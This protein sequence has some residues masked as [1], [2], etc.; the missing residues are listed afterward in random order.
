MSGR[1]R[2]RLLPACLALLTL[3]AS[4][5]FGEVFAVLGPDGSYLETRVVPGKDSVWTPLG[6]AA[7]PW[8]VLNQQGEWRG[9]GAP[10]IAED[11]TGGLPFAAWAARSGRG[12][13][14]IAVAT[15]DGKD[16]V[17]LGTIPGGAGKQ[18][19]QP[20]VAVVNGCLL[21]VWARGG[22]DSSIWA[23]WYAGDRWLP[24]FSV[25]PAGVTASSPG[26]LVAQGEIFVA[27]LT[28]A[29]PRIRFDAI[30]NQPAGLRASDGPT[31]MPGG[32]GRGSTGGSGSS[33]D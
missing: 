17:A 32:V 15:F 24:P 27:S 29:S 20:A 5:A 9:D 33:Q 13:R 26:I 28:D 14:D 11:P 2:Y 23:A 18:D 8:L 10:A 4:P 12:D 30:V 22:H 3:A 19:R 6:L 25:T 1:M 16:W 7:G 31:P 21:V